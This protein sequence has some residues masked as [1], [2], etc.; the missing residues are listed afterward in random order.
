MSRGQVWRIATAMGLGVRIGQPGR[1][2]TLY[3][4]ADLERMKAR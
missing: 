4:P 1:E 2:I 3:T